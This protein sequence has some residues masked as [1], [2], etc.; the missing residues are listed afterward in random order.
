M[1]ISKINS[2]FANLNGFWRWDNWREEWRR[3]LMPLFQ[4][5]Y[6]NHP[7]FKEWCDYLKDGYMFINSGKSYFSS[8]LEN[9]VENGDV[10]SDYLWYDG[11]DINGGDRKTEYSTEMINSY[12]VFFINIDHSELGSIRLPLISRKIYPVNSRKGKTR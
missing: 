3:Y 2:F 8:K 5:V 10:R 11:I 4:Y 7:K 9:I 12:K 1:D 6:P